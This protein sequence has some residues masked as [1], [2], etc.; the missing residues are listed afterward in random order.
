VEKTPDRLLKTKSLEISKEQ[1]LLE[2][3]SQDEAA[4][5]YCDHKLKLGLK[6]E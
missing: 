1:D 3:G 6:H 2:I 4:S 5:D